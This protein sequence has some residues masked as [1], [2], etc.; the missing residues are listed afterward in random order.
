MSSCWHAATIL[1]SDWLSGGSTGGRRRPGATTTGDRTGTGGPG[2]GRRT[3]TTGGHTGA[4]KIFATP[5][6]IFS[7][8]LSD[9]L[10]IVTEAGTETGTGTVGVTTSRG[11]LG[12]TKTTIGIGTGGGRGRGITT[13]ETGGRS[14]ESLQVRIRSSQYVVVVLLFLKSITFM[15]VWMFCLHSQISAF[16]TRYSA[17]EEELDRR[18]HRG[19][20]RPGNTGL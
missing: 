14:E 9:L 12:I 16:N 17:Y 10:I 5:T 19:Q 15:R 4:G 20:S 1:T 8:I 2:T 11:S 3:R 6:K 18:S 13:T 7:F